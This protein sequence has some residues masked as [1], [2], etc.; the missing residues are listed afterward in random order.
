MEEATRSM[1]SA[2]INGAALGVAMLALGTL[3]LWLYLPL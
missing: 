3:V 2:A 1:I